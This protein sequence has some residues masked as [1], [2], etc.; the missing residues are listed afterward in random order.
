MVVPVVGVTTNYDFFKKV[1]ESFPDEKH[2]CQLYKQGRNT[3]ARSWRLGEKPPPKSK[4]RREKANEASKEPGRN[5]FRFG[6]NCFWLKIK[7]PW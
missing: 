3:G 7:Y 4:E 1:T 2:C 6:L 5:F